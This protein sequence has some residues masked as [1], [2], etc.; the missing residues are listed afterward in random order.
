[1]HTS[2]KHDSPI[3]FDKENDDQLVDVVGEAFD[4]ASINIPEI[5]HVSLVRILLAQ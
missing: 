1:M 4:A 5:N 2:C 3:N